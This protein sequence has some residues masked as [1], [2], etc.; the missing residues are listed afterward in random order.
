MATQ[1]TSVNEAIKTLCLREGDSGLSRMAIYNSYI[2][3]VFNEFLYDVTRTTF[4][5]KYYIDKTNNTLAIPNE[6]LSLISIGY[7]DEFGAIQPLWYNS[8]M[9]KEMLYENSIPCNCGCGCDTTCNGAKVNSVVVDK[10]NIGGGVLKDRTTKIWTDSKGIIRKEVSYNNG[11]TN[12]VT[13]E[14]I[15]NLE[16]K[17]CGCLTSSTTNTQAIATI[18][19]ACGKMD[20]TCGDTECINNNKL[21]FTVSQQGN[22]LIFSSLY[23]IDHVILKFI[24][25]AKNKDDFKFPS[26]ALEAFIQGLRYYNAM[27]TGGDTQR[28]GY[29]Y[30]REVN[31]VKRR[32]HPYN[33]KLLMEAVGIKIN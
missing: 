27:N 22:L 23:D 14:E 30:Q 17:E 15:C 28:I 10:L 29:Y 33:Y 26:I 16:L 18:M 5:K 11:V 8:K 13:T 1:Y 9:P 25:I 4:T 32:L 19:D 6:V 12:V 20:Y 31:K 3:T 2:S 7:Q 21:G 24:G